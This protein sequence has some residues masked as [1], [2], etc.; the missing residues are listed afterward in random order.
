MR[1]RISRPFFASSKP[2]GSR[3]GI[4]SRRRSR[5]GQWES[6]QEAEAPPYSVLERRGK[7][8]VRGCSPSVRLGLI[9]LQECSLRFDAAPHTWKACLSHNQRTQAVVVVHSTCCRHYGMGWRCLSV[10]VSVAVGFGG[11]LSA[12]AEHRPSRCRMGRFSSIS[13]IS[14]GRCERIQTGSALEAISTRV[15]WRR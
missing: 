4:A 9:L 15:L 6:R 10:D 11:C 13:T 3:P 12:L 7:A 5:G 1:G 2:F 14:L 8:T